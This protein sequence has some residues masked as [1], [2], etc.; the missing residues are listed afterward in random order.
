MQ[1]LALRSGCLQFIC[2]WRV[3]YGPDIVLFNGTPPISKLS[4]GTMI[5]GCIFWQ[6]RGDQEIHCKTTLRSEIFA[7]LQ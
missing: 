4:A 7:L 5:L 3:Y 2:L 1:W 6:S